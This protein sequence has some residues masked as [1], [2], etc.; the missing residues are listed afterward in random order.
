MDDV[1]KLAAELSRV[2]R[3]SGIDARGAL[4]ALALAANGGAENEEVAVLV[5]QESGPAAFFA[6]G[7]RFGVVAVPGTGA[8]AAVPE[9]EAH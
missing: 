9:A 7:R 5:A 2:M 4:H 3:S 6:S 8:P 1:R